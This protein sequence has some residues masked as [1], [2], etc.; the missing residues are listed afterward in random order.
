M[1][2]IYII[3]NKRG[4]GESEIGGLYTTHAL[5]INAYFD[6]MTN[7]RV[8]KLSRDKNYF[9]WHLYKF[10]LDTSFITDDGIWSHTKIQKSSKYRIKFKNHGEVVDELKRVNRS[11]KIGKIISDV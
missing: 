7:N 8:N 4:A 11:E 10:P 6:I 9:G 1:E 3:A 2:Y 5:A